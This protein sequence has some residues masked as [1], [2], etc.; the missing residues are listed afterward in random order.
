MKI[1]TLSLLAGILLSTSFFA[2]K[3]N[4]FLFSKVN[5]VSSVTTIEAGWYK[6]TSEFMSNVPDARAVVEKVSPAVV[7]ITGYRTV[8]RYR[9][10]N[11]SIEMPFFRLSFPSPTSAQVMIDAGTGFF[12]D[13]SGYILTS[14]HVVSDTNAFYR[15]TL[16]D[17]T[18]ENARIIY[19]NPVDDV[20][21]I[22]IE[23]TNYP[24]LT[25][26]DSSLLTKG[27]PVLGMGNA[28][29]QTTNVTSVGAVSDLHENIISS[30]ADGTE[31]RLS[32]LFETTMQLYPG[33]SGGP[34]FDLSGKVIGIN[35]AIAVDQDHVSF[36][37]PIN[38][39]KEDLQKAMAQ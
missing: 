13:S 16:T 18:E 19:R 6:N 27:T 31:K 7:S 28:F 3:Q 34:T 15:V 25:L 36:S 4:A 9:T 21:V 14:E 23:G 11:T 2:H 12:V 35:D 32:D 17:G 39:A 1:F 20:A 5:P 24:A 10:R 26:G 38:Y 22:K 29:G 33:D 30:S 37:T 8:S